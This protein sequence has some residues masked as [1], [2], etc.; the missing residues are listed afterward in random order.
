M[1]VIPIIS[2]VISVASVCITLLV[3]INAREAVKNAK[4][5]LE[6][7]QDKYLYELR[8]DALTATKEV[9]MIWQ[10]A[11]SDVYHEKERIRKFEGALNLTIR[12]MFDDYEL[13]LLKPS[14]ENISDMRNKLEKSFDG[15][16]EDEAKLVIRKMG[17][18]S[19][20]YAGDRSQ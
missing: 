2:V 19:K 6:H 18:C 7:S 14:L 11:I 1:N 3:Y 9:E 4:K 12:K 16:T 17:W 10:T 13:G 15:I 8:R 20:K 5:A